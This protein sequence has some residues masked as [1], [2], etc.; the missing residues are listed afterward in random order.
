MNMTEKL[1]GEKSVATNK[2]AFHEYFILEKI[3][4]GICLFGTEVKAI[5]EG[6]LNL[7]DS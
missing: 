5:R 6:R 7:K 4:A 3:E 1:T 2:K